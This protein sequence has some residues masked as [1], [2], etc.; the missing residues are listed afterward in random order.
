MTAILPKKIDC[1][2]KIKEKKNGRHMA[3]RLIRINLNSSP[4]AR[5]ASYF[6]FQIISVFF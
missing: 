6:N 1:S 2:N 3:F 5:N 4:I